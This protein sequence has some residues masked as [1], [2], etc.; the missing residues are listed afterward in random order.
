[1]SCWDGVFF[2]PDGKTLA[3]YMVW[4]DDDGDWVV[5]RRTMFRTWEVATGK[6]RETFF[7]QRAIRA[8]AFAPDGKTLVVGC[9]G[10]FKFREVKPGTIAPA[11]R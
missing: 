9:R 3:A 11:A 10:G 4:Q 6:V 5:Q 2:S 7:V 8:A 1:V